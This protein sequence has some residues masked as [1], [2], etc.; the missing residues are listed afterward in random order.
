M[1]EDTP[2]KVINQNFERI[3][4]SAKKRTCHSYEF[5]MDQLL[6]LE[7]VIEK[8]EKEIYAAKKKD[9]GMGEV[10]TYVTTIFNVQSGKDD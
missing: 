9:L 1:M 6:K 3:S 8:Y 5:R 2:T 10:G 7:S 4:A